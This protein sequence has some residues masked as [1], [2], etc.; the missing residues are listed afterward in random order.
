MEHRIALAGDVMLARG[1]D[2]IQ[3]HR[4]GPE[5]HEPAVT[6]ARAYVTLAERSSGKIPAM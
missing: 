1:I 4:T 3:R 6:D 5:L 2:Q